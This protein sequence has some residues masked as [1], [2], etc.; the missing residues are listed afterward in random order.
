VGL[1]RQRQG[2]RARRRQLPG[3]F[4]ENFVKDS[5]LKFQEAYTAAGGHNAVFNFPESGVH[6]WEYWGDQLVKMIPDMQNSL[7]ASGA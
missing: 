7:G 3:Q 5:N 4:L 6:S 1:L 2:Q